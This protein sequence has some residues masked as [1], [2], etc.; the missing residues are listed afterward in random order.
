MIVHLVAPLPIFHHEA[1]LRVYF[2][3]SLVY[4]GIDETIILFS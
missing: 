2:K 4:F 3:T 1:Y